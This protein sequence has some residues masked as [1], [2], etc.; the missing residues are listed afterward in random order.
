MSEDPATGSAALG[1]GVFLVA[2]GL[3]PADGESS[4]EIAQGVDFAPG[5]IFERRYGGSFTARMHGR[6]HSD[7]A[8]S[9]QAWR[10]GLPRVVLILQAGNAFSWFG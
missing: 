8:I 9:R 1:L 4:Y 10:T 2:C 5:P 6:L 7:A 3:P